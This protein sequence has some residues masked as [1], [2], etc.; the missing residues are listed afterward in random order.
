VVGLD[1]RGK[2]WFDALP[3]WSPVIPGRFNRA[4][5]FVANH[6]KKTAKAIGLHDGGAGSA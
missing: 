1:L 2:S 4:S 5:E 6:G 3:G